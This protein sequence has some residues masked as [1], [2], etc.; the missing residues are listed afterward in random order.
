M[1]HGEYAK[2]YKIDQSKV[3]SLMDSWPKNVCMHI[4]KYNIENYYI[5]M[6]GYR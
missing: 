4:R 2:I 1:E 6:F 5:W 3:N